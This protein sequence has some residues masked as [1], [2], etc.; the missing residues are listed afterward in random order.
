[1]TGTTAGARIRC[2]VRAGPARATARV[3]GTH[4]RGPRRLEGVPSRERCVGT[5][6]ISS[7]GGRH[8]IGQMRKRVPRAG[9]SPRR[10]RKLGTT[11]ATSCGR[12]K[13][14]NLRGPP[15]LTPLVAEALPRC[16]AG[17]A[18][19]PARSLRGS[20]ILNPH[21]ATRFP[22]R[23]CRSQGQARQTDHDRIIAGRVK[24][25]VESAV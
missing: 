24:V 22:V 11:R 16:V 23:G 13:K 20:R 10:G 5:A 4:R 17:G 7:G 2:A 21:R 9:T 14:D 1:M 6:P 25:C 19:C 18:P 15:P 8:G 12:L 3:H